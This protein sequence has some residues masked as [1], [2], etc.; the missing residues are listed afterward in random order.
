MGQRSSR[1][2]LT[3][4]ANLVWRTPHP[5]PPASTASA[6]LAASRVVPQLREAIIEGRL[7]PGRRL[8]EVE[9]GELCG[10]SRTP[11][12]EAFAQLE[13]EGLVVTVARAGAYVAT[14]DQR[15]VDE[16]YETREAI[17]TQAARLA[18]RRL[19]AVGAA[20]LEERLAALAAALETGD[21]PAYTAELDRFYDVL[22]D[23]AG[24]QTLRRSYEAL[25]GPVRR[26]RRIAMRHPGRIAASLDHARAIVDAISRRDED[27]AEREMRAQLT[28]ARAAVTAVLG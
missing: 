15:Q 21:T 5:A 26:L 16:I 4:L 23:L 13:R 9:I 6:S 17:E 28:T 20:R 25:S 8:S 7:E 10:V 11:A 3:P 24:N 22:L 27:A 14:I 2:S 18:A 19:G 1:N 12:R